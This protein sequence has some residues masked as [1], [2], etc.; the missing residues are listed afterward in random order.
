MS[1]SAAAREV[2]K[3]ISELAAA[4]ESTKHHN[5]SSVWA[6]AR[7]STL[8]T[9]RLAAAR[10]GTSQTKKSAAAR[11]STTCTKAIRKT[12]TLSPEKCSNKSL[13]LLYQIRHCYIFQSCQSKVAIY[14]R[15]RYGHP[16]M[17][18][19]AMKPL[20]YHYLSID[21]ASAAR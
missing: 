6:A 17:G 1:R 4:R 8:H 2:T 19:A 21:F 7:E 15:H 16:R 9:K 10:D 13:A 5:P 20:A 11:E 18:S 3:L 12:P 14:T